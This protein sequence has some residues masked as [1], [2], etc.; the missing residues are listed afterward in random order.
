VGAPAPAPAPAEGRGARRV[1]MV[2]AGQG[3][4]WAGCGRELY[5][6]EPAFR[7]AVDAVDALDA[8]WRGQAGFSLRDA[9]F[10][11]P[12]ERLDECE[13]AQPVIFM[14][15][16]A[17]TELLKTWGVHPGCVIGHS[18]GEAAAAYA[19]GHCDLAEA[20]RLVFHRA[21]LEQ[22]TAR[23]GRMLAVALNRAG[24]EEI[25][26]EAGT[27]ALEI[28]CENAPASTVICGPGE[29]VAR[30]VAVLEQRRVPHRLL[31]GNVAFH[32]RA[33]D[34][35]E[36]D[37]RA[38]LAFLDHRHLRAEIPFVSSVTGEVT[39]NLDAAYWWS[40]VRRP[41]RFMAAVRAAARD[42]RPDVVLEVSPHT[43]LTPAVR[44]TLAREGQR[45]TC[46]RTLARGE[47]PRLSLRRALGAL[48]RAG[49]R[50]E[51]VTEND[52]R[53]E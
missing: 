20:A 30:A 43:T 31:R 18:V 37:L 9:C 1:L 23:S 53:M 16:V 21:T 22:R 11:A 13:L 14:I 10:G 40:N 28:A 33:M 29:D 5:E 17:L 25:L 7:R 6:T 24:A 41:V 32:S 12:Q 15:E 4:Q 3:T 35:I 52:V 2:F 34:V 48:S 46:V 36:A 47:D 44:Q 42:F 51:F 45:P 50:T 19:A 49:V 38:S 8:A 27:R 39:E 26:R